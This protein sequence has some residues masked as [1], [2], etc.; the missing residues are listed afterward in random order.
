MRKLAWFVLACTALIVTVSA[1]SSTETYI[2]KLKKERKLINGFISDND[3]VVLDKYPEDGVFEKNQ[4]YRDD[5]TG[6]YFQ[7]V[8]PG[9]NE[10][11]VK[12]KTKVFLRYSDAYYLDVDTVKYNNISMIGVEP[13]EFIYGN[14]HTYTCAT[15]NSTQQYHMYMFLSPAC[16]LPLE[17]IG[18]HAEIKLIVPFGSGSTYQNSYYKTLFIGKLTYQ[19]ELTQQE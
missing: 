12:E 14:T 1:C 2:E 4:Y 15:T 18:N 5:S 19:F 10:R 8:D 17:K 3:I 6:I 16:A 11:A 13:M 7:V 9:N